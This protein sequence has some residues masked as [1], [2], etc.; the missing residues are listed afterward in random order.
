[1]Y[2]CASVCT[3]IQVSLESRSVRCPGTG[4]IGG[5]GQPDVGAGNQTQVLWKSSKP[6]T[7]E[8]PLQP[9]YFWFGL[10]FPDSFI[11]NSRPYFL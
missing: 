5:Y 4:H 3:C 8:L 2:V 9:I 1:M 10:V 7:S 11:F 6:L